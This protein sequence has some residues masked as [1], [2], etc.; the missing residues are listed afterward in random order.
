MRIPALVER[1]QQGDRDAYERLAT[2]AARRLYLIAYRIVRDRDR[3]DDAAQ[4][5]LVAIWRELPTLRDPER[6]ESWDVPACGALLPRRIA[7]RA[8]QEHE[9]GGPSQ[10]PCPMSHD[11]LAQIPE[12][13][14]E[15]GFG[16]SAS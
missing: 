1:A 11:A 5:T 10:T 6:F 7:S 4:Q 16:P 15:A 2:E 8:A 14:D 12:P 9:P 13:H 3:A